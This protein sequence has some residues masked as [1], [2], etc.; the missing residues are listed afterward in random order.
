MLAGKLVVTLFLLLALLYKLD[1]ESFRQVISRV[2]PWFLFVAFFVTCAS[3]VLVAFR[4]QALLRSR[5]YYLQL[6]AL[7]RYYFVGI[8]SNF[9]L[10]TVIGGD[11]TR[12]YYLRKSGVGWKEAIGS[13][14]VER[15]LGFAATVALALVA[16]LLGFNLVADMSIKI[17]V[18]VFGVGC[19]S[20][21]LFLYRRTAPLNF[22]I[23]VAGKL[24]ALT[25]LIQIA[26]DYKKTRVLGYAFLISVASQLVGIASIYCIGLS[27][28][29]S[30]GFAYYLILLPITWLV[31]MVPISINGLGLREGAF[32]FL[33]VSVGMTKEMAFAISAL[34]LLQAIAQG[35]IGGLF[36]VAAPPQKRVV[37]RGSAKE[38]T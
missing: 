9:F 26:Q 15:I 19:F 13:I 28:G 12:G 31:S 5:H 16:T 33:F 29:S 24:K 18:I 7:T 22:R 23:P 4:W 17:G 10:P 25:D 20:A 1:V 2:N 27:L 6:A 21:L 14:M 3:N 32:V 36:F 30:T 34:S 11:I 8:F 37:E 38:L 35:M